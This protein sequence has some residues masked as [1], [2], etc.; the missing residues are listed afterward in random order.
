MMLVT[1]APLLRDQLSIA[2]ST[3][4]SASDV[5]SGSAFACMSLHRLRRLA[6]RWI[7]NFPSRIFDLKSL[8]CAERADHKLASGP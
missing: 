8:I 7:K 4:S 1:S 3:C 5:L 6:S 2:L